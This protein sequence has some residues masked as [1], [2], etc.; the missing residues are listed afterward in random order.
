MTLALTLSSDLTAAQFQE[1][2]AAVLLRAGEGTHTARAYTRALRDFLAWYD[3]CQRDT[4]GR[5][6]P[7]SRA[8]IYRYRASLIE[9]GIS[10]SSVNQ[11]LAPIRR[12]ALELS[13]G[14]TPLISASDAAAIRGVEG[15]A[16]RGR[17]IG[18]WLTMEQAQALINHPNVMTKRGLRDRAILA[19]FLGAGV[20]RYEGAAL[21]VEHF[22]QREGRW[23]IVDLYGKHHR[24]RSIPVAP[25]VYVAVR[26]W[27][28]GAHITS[29]PIW[30]A[31][32]RGDR[33]VGDAPLTAQAIRNI[34]K[35]NA[36]AI[37]VGEIAPHDLRRTFAKLARK[38]GASL[39]QI[40]FSLGHSNVSITADYVGR[41]Q[42]FTTAP[43]D[44]IGLSVGK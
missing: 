7:F 18:R 5:L 9:R 10:A 35:R 34:I 33:I 36:E 43:S 40:Q 37:G 3:T 6:L 25:W 27:L 30:R 2:V 26:A 38:G 32:N 12:M 4:S 13:Q 8:L 41:E 14:D 20:R 23:A 29:G 21:T 11:R 22:Q 19:V 17:R 15:V 31:V 28:D 1:A 39:E 16:Q 44:V 24:I 42:D